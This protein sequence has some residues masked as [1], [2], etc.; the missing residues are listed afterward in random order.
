[1]EIY[2]EN[3]IPDTYVWQAN[4]VADF[5]SLGGSDVAS[6]ALLTTERI[7]LPVEPVR[8]NY[9]FEGWYPNEDFEEPWS[10]S[11]RITDDITLYAQWTAIS[12]V[13]VAYVDEAGTPLSETVCLSGASGT[14]VVIVEKPFEGYEFLKATDAAGVEIDYRTVVFENQ[15]QVITMHYGTESGENGVVTP[16]G[17][18]SGELPQTGGVRNL[19]LWII[20]PFIAGTALISRALQKKYR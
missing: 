4:L 16:D 3:P 2:K 13:S 1:M 7:T 15:P 8:E 6:Q 17:T 18:I 14:A 12:N 19:C 10:F 11:T 5:D 20:L 9:V